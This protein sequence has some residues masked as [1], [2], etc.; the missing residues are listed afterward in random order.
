[1]LYL[2]ED[3]TP[4]P[5]QFGALPAL[6]A[7]T[8]DAELR[9]AGGHFNEQQFPDAHQHVT[10][11]GRLVA[12]GLIWRT[13]TGRPDA[14]EP[15]HEIF[16]LART[17]DI[18]LL[19]QSFDAFSTQ[20]AE[21]VEML[22]VVHG[23]DSAQ[24]V[25]DGSGVVLQAHRDRYGRWRSTEAAAS[26]A[27]GPSITIALIGRECDQHQQYPAT[28]AAL[29]DAADALGFDLDVRF[30]AAQEINRD[31]AE[32]MLA[33]ALG[34]LLPD[35]ADIARAAGQIEAA[36]FGWLASIPVVGLSLGMQSMATAI[37]RLA[38]KSDEISMKLAHPD[39]GLASVDPI[40]VGNDGVLLHRLGLRPI[41]LVPGSRVAAI[42]GAQA[43]ILCNHRYRLN[44]AL[45]APL[46]TLGVTVS[47][48][49]ESGSI[50]DAIE[51][52]KHPF[53]VGMQGHPELSS[54]DGAPHPLLMAF[55]KAA[56][57]R[58]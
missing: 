41:S 54:R 18:V 22:R 14:A 58:S 42:H 38:L 40:H 36:R 21:D 29:G 3:A 11:D 34:I 48:H 4:R 24:L 16:A 17:R 13:R 45:E 9:C 49:D 37:A 55:L 12:S 6:F 57:S 15:C 20:C 43:R 26:R 2:I 32:T 53:F 56:A 30:I 23:A 1:M 27:R 52:D 33:D 7:R 50:A 51:A 46:A 39:A 28:L 19:V 8:L 5:A 31:N 10:A 47:A 44:P 35:G 25:E